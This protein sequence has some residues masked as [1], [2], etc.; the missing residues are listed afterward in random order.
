VCACVCVCMHAPEYVCVPAT[1]I[2]EHVE[3]RRGVGVSGLEL[4]TVGSC[5]CGLGSKPKSYAGTVIEL[6]RT[7]L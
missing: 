4:E 2:Q 5:R 7:S 1:F 6:S 3:I